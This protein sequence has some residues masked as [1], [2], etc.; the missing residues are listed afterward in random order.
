MHSEQTESS[1][2]FFKDILSH[3]IL[4]SPAGWFQRIAFSGLQDA[5][6]IEA[7]RLVLLTNLYCVV[8]VFFL[9]FFSFRSLISD[10]WELGLVLAGC[11]LLAFGNILY[12]RFSGNYQRAGDAVVV[13]VSALCFY[14]LATGGVE[15]TGPLWSYTLPPLVLFIYG[16]S[17][18]GL[19]LAGFMLASLGLMHIPDNGLLIADYSFSFKTRYSSTFLVVCFISSIC[20]YARFHSYGVLKKLQ[21]RVQREAHT[22]ELTGLSNRRYMYEQINRE[23]RKIQRYDRPYSLM[24]CDL[25]HFKA[26]NDE[27]GHPCGDK[28]LMDVALRME[29]SLRGEDT[30]ARWGGEEFL[31]LLPETEEEEAVLAAEKLLKAVSD[32][33]IHC[34][35][36]SLSVTMSIGVAQIHME[37]AIETILRKVDDAMYEAKRNGRNR[38]EVHR[39]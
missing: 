23:L 8:G 28:V 25:D 9:G 35:H 5:R 36:Q 7:Q 10:R 6:D 16:L 31:I 18:G 1:G 15:N 37:C 4:Q 32:S 17:K 19:V 29:N 24:L 12:L 38:I 22:D 11:G 26:I 27:Y 33:P 34:G 14:L 13:A 39:F 21:Q 3:Q 2:N 20:E 30:V